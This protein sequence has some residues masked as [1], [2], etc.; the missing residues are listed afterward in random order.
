MVVPYGDDV[1]VR[2]SFLKSV[3]F[4]KY[5]LYGFFFNL[6]IMKRPMTKIL[7]VSFIITLDYSYGV[8]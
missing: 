3:V 1:L 8:G 5:V 6:I 2:I 7:F 4:I